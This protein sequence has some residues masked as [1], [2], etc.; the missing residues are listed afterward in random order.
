MTPLLR[1]HVLA[2]WVAPA[3]DKGSSSQN[4]AIN[5]QNLGTMGVYQQGDLSVLLCRVNHSK[6]PRPSV[7]LAVVLI[8]NTPFGSLAAEKQLF[9]GDT[10][11]HTSNSFDAFLNGNTS[12]GPEQAYRFARGLPVE[13][14][15]HKA[16]MQLRTPLDF[17]VVADHAENLGVA[18]AVYFGNAQSAD[19]GLIDRLKAWL[20]GRKLREVVDEEKGWDFFTEFLPVSGNPS[21]AAKSLWEDQPAQ[22]PGA[23]AISADSWREATS[24]ADQYTL[25]GEFTAFIGWEWSSLPGGANLHRVVLTDADAEVAQQYMP[26]GSDQSPYPEDLWQWLETT[27]SATG[28]DFLAIPHNSNISKGYMFTA[29]SLRGEPMSR[30]KLTLRQRWERVVEVT[31][32]KGDSETHPLLSPDDPFAEFETYPFYIQRESQPYK[33]EPGDYIRSALKL[34]MDI[35]QRTGVNPFQ[36]GVI[37]STD[38]HTGL[39]TAEENNFGGKLVRDSTPSTMERPGAGNGV[40]SGW[41]MSASGLAAVWAEE[42]TR[43]SLFAAMQ[44]REVY[45]TTGP[46]IRLRVAA[47]WG[48]QASKWPMGAV[49]PSAPSGDASP[50]IQVWAEKDPIDANLDRIQVIKLWR[51]AAGGL[52]EKVFNVAWSGAR[53]LDKTGLLPAVGDTVDRSQARFTNDIGAAQLQADWTD[54][55]FDPSQPALYYVRVLQIPTPRQSLFNALALGLAEPPRG[56]SVIQ[57]RAYSSPVW[58]QPE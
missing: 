9:W 24:L 15:Y 11:L 31:Q 34:G 21:V 42:N 45:A 40:T 56:P 52:Q 18:R 47:G 1:T 28:S 38:A 57:E 8:L 41:N 51:S 36:F 12:V 19:L 39:A 27:A 48:E 16:W 35:A 2:G 5:R 32:I 46:R 14:P 58:Y 53:D 10:H 54:P 30:E 25:P 55:A 43:E 6:T 13:H 37:G 26:F 23:Q 4:A 17:L 22:F 3:L 33:P 20:G 49:L 44:R 7:A 50:R 29:D